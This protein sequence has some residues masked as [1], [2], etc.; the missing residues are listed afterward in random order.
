MTIVIA[1]ETTTVPAEKTGAEIEEM[2]KKHGARRIVKEYDAATRPSGIMFEMV[3]DHGPI[4]VK[5]PIKIDAVYKIL[6]D[7]KNNPWAH[8]AKEKVYAQAERTAWRNVREWIHSQLAMV[9]INLVTVT[10]A[11][12]P[13]MLMDDNQTAYE[14]MLEGG[15]PAL[16]A[17]KSK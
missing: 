2:L 15:M 6:L 4:P 9:Q 13:Y 1:F 8:G 10:E 14:R 12:M 7:R 16:M 3:T 5:L 17:P 11:F